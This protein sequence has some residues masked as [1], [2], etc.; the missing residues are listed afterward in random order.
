MILPFQEVAKHGCIRTNV[1][2]PVLAVKME[3]D[4]LTGG[5]R[6]S[7][8]ASAVFFVVMHS[9]FMQVILSGYNTLWCTET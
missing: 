3:F 5:R 8:K 4:T 7:V 9:L 1:I 6:F 2:Q